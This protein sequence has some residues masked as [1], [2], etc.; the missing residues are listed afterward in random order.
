MSL[1]PE[2]RLM[3]GLSICAPHAVQVSVLKN[4]FGFIK[5]CERAADLMFHAEG[6]EGLSIQDLKE[7]DEVEFEVAHKPHQASTK[8]HQ[9]S[10][11]CAV[12]WD[13]QTA[14]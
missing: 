9:P 5:A 14:P 6:L 8:P 11:L 3:L 13:T 1:L 12:R 7:G 2:R 10:K 4:N